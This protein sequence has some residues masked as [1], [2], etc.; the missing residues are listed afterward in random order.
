MPVV[1]RLKIMRRVGKASFYNF[2]K[3]IATVQ[4]FSEMDKPCHVGRQ[5]EKT[6]E[7][8]NHVKPRIF[9]QKKLKKLNVSG[10]RC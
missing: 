7:Y 1:I 10:K 2:T 8:Q 5:Q 3:K 9:T 6:S 4:S